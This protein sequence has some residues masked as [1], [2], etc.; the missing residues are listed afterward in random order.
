MAV[1]PRRAICHG[2]IR[3]V[4]EELN[5]RYDEESLRGPDGVR[6]PQYLTRWLRCMLDAECTESGNITS[7]NVTR[8]RAVGDSAARVG[9]GHATTS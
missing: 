5:S 9:G 2:I 7:N 8:L 3:M 4:A 1:M 6:V